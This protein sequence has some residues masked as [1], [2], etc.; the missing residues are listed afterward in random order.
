MGV[1]RN[2]LKPRVTRFSCLAILFSDEHEV[3]ECLDGQPNVTL[4][5]DCPLVI[6]IKW[7][8]LT[9]VRERTARIDGC[10]LNYTQ[11]EDQDRSKENEN[12]NEGNVTLKHRQQLKAC[13]GQSSCN[14]PVDRVMYPCIRHL[15]VYE[16]ITYQCI[17]PDLPPQGKVFVIL[18]FV[19]CSNG[20]IYF[21]S[22]GQSYT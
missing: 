17:Q 16:H 2:S 8:D 9:F 21:G 14:V 20:N 15:S 22:S 10:C 5:C 1:Y 6:D 19:S 11:S 12:K 3:T 18:L 13:N 7:D 4:S